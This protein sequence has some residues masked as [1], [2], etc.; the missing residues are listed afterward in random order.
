M[1][2]FLAAQARAVARGA[3]TQHRIPVDTRLTATPLRP[4]RRHGGR[5]FLPVVDDVLTIHGGHYEDRKW[6]TTDKVHCKI[7]HIQ[8][9]P[10]GWL[11]AD[12]AQAE[13]HSSV[14]EFEVAWVE[15][16]DRAWLDRQIAELI[17]HKVPEREAQETRPEWARTRYENRWLAREVWTLTLRV[18]DDMP[19]ILPKLPEEPEAIPVERIRPHW[20]E[21][22][23]RRHEKAVIEARE[24][25]RV[26]LSREQR[27]QQLHRNAHLR[28]VD[29]SRELWLLR[30]RLPRLSQD[31]LE[32]HIRV[33]EDR[34]F[35][36]AA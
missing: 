34:V 29:V 18:F 1:P 12:Q 13:G 9:G 32:R 17:E 20:A 28:G 27:L 35:R 8:R 14:A 3:K 7:T 26:L 33:V 21:W 11:T 15:R 2:R 6:V 16:H 31:S 24:R 23:A 19:L 30:A 10:L 4:T 25:D 36:S 5:P 22:A